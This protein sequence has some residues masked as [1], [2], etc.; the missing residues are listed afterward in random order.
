MLVKHLFGLLLAGCTLPCGLLAQEAAWELKSKDERL[1]LYTRKPDGSRLVEVR[2]RMNLK[3]S[4]QDLLAVLDDLETYPQWVY[5]CS[6]A[7]RVNATKGYYYQSIVDLPFPFSDRDVVAQ[8]QQ[9][10]DSRTGKTTRT[11]RA[12]PNV[13]PGEKG[14]E[15]IE[16]YEAVWEIQ[17]I[18]DTHILIDYR[19]FT[20]TGGALPSWIVNEVATSGPVKSMRRLAE[21][22]EK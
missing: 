14:M 15:R 3:A 21:L 5:R 20:D 11:V 18:S 9:R 1:E 6:S 2:I 4:P 22:V 10:T 13:I 7:R 17:S 12:A 16:T 19:C 8:V